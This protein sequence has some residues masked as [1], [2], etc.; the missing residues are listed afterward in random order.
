LFPPMGG[1]R[2]ARVHRERST[3]RADD[4]ERRRGRRASCAWEDYRNSLANHDIYGLRFLGNGQPPTVG[5]LGPGSAPLLGFA[6]ANPSRGRTRFTLTL[7]FDARTS[8]SVYNPAGRRVATLL[9]DASLSAGPH[10]LAWDGLDALGRLRCAR[11][12]R[13]R[14]FARA[15]RGPRSGSCSFPRG[16]STCAPPPRSCCSRSR[17]RASATPS[18]SLDPR[19]HA[20]RKRERGARLERRGSDHVRRPQR[21]GSNFPA[22]RAGPVRRRGRDSRGSTIT[23]ATLTLNMSQAASPASSRSS[24]SRC[25]PTGAKARRTPARRARGRRPRRP[26]TRPGST[27]SSTATFGTGGRRR[28]RA[29][30]S[31]A[32]AVGVEGPYSWSGSGLVADAQAWLDTA[33]SNHGWLLR[34]NE[35]T[36]QSVKRF[37]TR[38]AVLESARPSSR[39]STR[40]RE[41]RPGPRAGA[42]PRLLPLGRRRDRARQVRLHAVAFA[43]AQV[44]AVPHVLRDAASSS[45]A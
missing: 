12:V 6:G 31:G 20:L 7:P 23:A 32:Q 1:R 11:H 36:S 37:D 5:V 30:A 10:A 2:A 44:Q 21:V 24:S 8:A 33:S 26:A 43:L 16:L 34:G 27:V 42:D 18:R 41:R 13:H 28:L 14:R 4:R 40:P 39:S 35:T 17:S 9:N 22:A 25:S 19:Q 29:A 3:G 15:D 38:E 45:F